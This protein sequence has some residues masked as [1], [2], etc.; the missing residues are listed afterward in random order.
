M[1]ARGH[2]RFLLIGFL[3]DRHLSQSNKGIPSTGF[4]NFQYNKHHMEK[5]VK[6]SNKQ[7]KDPRRPIQM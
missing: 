3:F 7:K 5:R 1:Q 6:F 2:L 4:I